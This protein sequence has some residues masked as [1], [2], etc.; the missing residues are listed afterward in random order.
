[1]IVLERVISI[2]AETVDLDAG[3]VDETTKL[4]EAEWI[5]SLDLAEFYMAIEDEF[6][7]ELPDRKCVDFETVG[8]VAREVQMQKGVQ[9]LK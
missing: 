5:D 4:R 3:K 9:E 6:S 8:D 2:Y 1:M 7:V